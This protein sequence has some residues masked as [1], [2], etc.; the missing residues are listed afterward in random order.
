MDM[1]SSYIRQDD[2]FFESLTIKEHLTFNV[3]FNTFK[4]KF[5][6]FFDD[7]KNLGIFK[8]RSKTK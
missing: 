5:S 1:I 6:H 2:L 7:K 3:S 4:D 8:I